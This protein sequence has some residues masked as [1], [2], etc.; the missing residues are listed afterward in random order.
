MVSVRVKSYDAE[1]RCV[2]LHFSFFNIARPFP[3][4]NHLF[5]LPEERCGSYEEV[6]ASHAPIA[7]KLV[8]T[9]LKNEF[10]TLRRMT[11][12]ISVIPPKTM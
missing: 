5:T 1:S 12:E 3:F 9:R 6:V 10:S 7:V 4:R 2:K 8:C 11:V